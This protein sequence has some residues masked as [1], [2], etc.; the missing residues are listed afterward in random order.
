MGHF[1]RRQNDPQLTFRSVEVWWRSGRILFLA[2]VTI[3]SL[4]TTS[5][6]CSIRKLLVLLC[7]AEKFIWFRVLFARGNSHFRSVADLHGGIFQVSVTSAKNNELP[8]SP[9]VR[10]RGCGR[11]SRA[12][13]EKKSGASERPLGRRETFKVPLFFSWRAGT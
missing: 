4:T 10:L 11:D 2:P 13:H 9:I 8:Q 3:D 7:C 5:A 12:N 1:W 6:W